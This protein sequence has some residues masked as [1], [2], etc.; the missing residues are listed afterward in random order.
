[1]GAKRARE[2]KAK[3]IWISLKNTNHKNLV[4]NFLLK[5]PDEFNSFIAYKNRM[6]EMVDLQIPIYLPKLINDPEYKFFQEYKQRV[7]ALSQLL[8]K[9]GYSAACDE[10][11]ELLE[12]CRKDLIYENIKSK[13]LENHP[14]TMNEYINE[15]VCNFDG[16]DYELFTHFLNILREKEFKFDKKDVIDSIYKAQEREE[17]ESFEKDLLSSDQDDIPDDYEFEE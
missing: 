13:I 9:K 2:E 4:T 5:H 7:N 11:I 12:E 8:K 14:H 10:T 3:Q 16:Q 1:M 6:Q 17:L 15:F